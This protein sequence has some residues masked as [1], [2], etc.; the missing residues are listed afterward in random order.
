MFADALPHCS[1][2]IPGGE[3]QP[4]HIHALVDI[5]PAGNRE[6]TAPGVGAHAVG[7][8]ASLLDLLLEK[9]ESL[10]D[11]GVHLLVR[12]CNGD[13]V[14]LALGQEELWV[15]QQDHVR[16][17]AAHPLLGPLQLR[18]QIRRRNTMPT[19]LAVLNHVLVIRGRL[20]SLVLRQ[21]PA[22]KVA[23]LGADNTSFP[24]NLVLLQ[25]LQGG[26]YS[27]LAGTVLVVSCGVDKIHPLGHCSRDHR[28]VLHLHTVAS[29]PNRSDGKWANSP[30]IAGVDRRSETLQELPSGGHREL[31]PSTTHAQSHQDEPWQRKLGTTRCR[32]YN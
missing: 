28:H 27:D 25:D 24:G 30:H 17:H 26:S 1:R 7:L 20:G 15:M 12:L 10:G 22:L 13:P 31:M 8:D 29:N 3:D 5:G 6:E 18:L 23:I 4:L 32:E 2:R 9:G 21:R 19:H 14:F 11:A 16:V